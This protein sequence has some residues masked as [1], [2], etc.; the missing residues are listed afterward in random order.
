M[1]HSYQVIVVGGGHAGVEAALISSRM[2]ASTLLITH[3][4][5][6]IGQMSCNPAIGGLGKGHLV[7][8][9]DA[10]FGEM[11]MAIDDTG[12]QF[13]TLNSS[14]G[15]AV[16]S[17]R[18]QADRELYQK[19]I[20]KAVKNCPNLQIT[21]EP[22]KSII[23][24]GNRI[25][26]I[27]TETGQVFK[28]KCV[29]L[30]T[31]T[32]LRGLMHT[33]E[34]KTEGG[35]IGEKASTSL[36]DSIKALGLRMG[37]LKTGTPPRIK[38]DSINFSK[39][40]E[41]EGENPPRP[42]SFRT[43]KINRP[44][45]SCWITQTNEKTHDIIRKNLDR[46]PMFNGQ[47]NSGGPRYC[48]SIEDKIF[49]FSEKTSHTI[50]LEPEGYESKI[51]YPNGISTSLPLDVQHE[52]VR[53]IVGLEDAEIIVP[54]YAVEYDHVDPTELDPNF[55]VR[56]FDGLY[57]AGQINGTSGYE[58]AAAQGL[59][60][61][62]NAVL[63]TR[64][65]PPLYL[66]RDQAYIGVMADDLTALGV[67]EP[68]RMFTSRAEYRLHLREDNADIRLTP[69][70]R[71]L[72]LVP[73][74]DWKSFEERRER[75]EREKK[76]LSTTFLKP[77]PEHN[78]ILSSSGSAELSDSASL[79]SLLRRPELNYEF[80]TKHFPSPMPLDPQEIVSVEVEVKFSGYL[81]R[82]SEEI[83]RIKKMEDEVIPDEFT[84]S[85]INGLSVEVS[86]R[87]TQVRPR[88]L[89]QAAR[90]SGVTP[91]AISL[92]AVHLKR[93]KTLSSSSKKSDSAFSSAKQA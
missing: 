52:L 33:G 72:G 61:G 60:A 6:K 32:F 76:R 54:G 78:Q 44:Q 64:E 27:E 11:G 8:E 80:I 41:Q 69:I 83:S 47:I 68:Y 4:E 45:V 15:P 19:R 34:V 25:T 7:R 36:S 65:Q 20:L 2:G 70:A 30:T 22:A 63:E 42:F 3:A 82:Q 37:R 35:R 38:L 17:S 50:F 43:K 59:I 9:I 84:Y 48:P 26:G 56:S 62:I 31:G 49:R 28:A 75:I 91:A 85:G 67:K 1:G 40:E 5:N 93:V 53:T 71:K 79:A 23:S 73:D 55:K 87:L 77:V 13:R 10:L 74:S 92:L 58:E 90:I 12:I 46:S 86:E 89:G 66:G 57:L 39:C 88:T 16:R 51:V 21:S 24:S 29:V 18:A 81:K 14:K